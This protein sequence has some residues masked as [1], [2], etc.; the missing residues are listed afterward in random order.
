[1]QGG[2]F[3]VDPSL[4]L[5]HDGPHTRRLREITMYGDPVVA[6]KPGFFGKDPLQVRHNIAEKQG[7]PKK[8]GEGL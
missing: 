4:D 3:L 7:I 8:D 1:M 5:L 6:L 2:A